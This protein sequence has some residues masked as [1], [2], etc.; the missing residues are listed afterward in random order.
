MNAYFETLI[1]S[2][3]SFFFD[4][5]GIYYCFEGNGLS[6]DGKNE[7]ALQTNQFLLACGKSK[8]T[9]K[10]NKKYHG[11]ARLLRVD[12]S[13][14]ELEKALS[15]LE[16]R[17]DLKDFSIFS[18]IKNQH[19][20]KYILSDDNALN[21]YHLIYLIAHEFNHNT[22]G[23]DVIC[24]NALSSLVLITSRLY[25]YSKNENLN[26]V[27]P[28]ADIDYVLKYIYQNISSDLSLKTL[29]ENLGYSREHLCRYFKKETNTNLSKYIA[30]QR[31]KRAISRMDTDEFTIS[32]I[33]EYAG[34]SSVSAFER[35]FKKI[36][37]KSPS[38][39]KKKI[40]SE[41]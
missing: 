8:V 35:N 2:E 25:S 13:K 4:G 22:T 5:I 36:T 28:K 24:S 21:V 12:F 3:I 34:F 30:S 32:E 18:S 26:M 14:K 19:S 16:D 23:S 40:K 9:L 38:E 1:D 33:A 29:A 31:V 39:Y 41:V 11:L 6:M 37:G 15:N 10:A 27:T 17:A 7:F 20:F